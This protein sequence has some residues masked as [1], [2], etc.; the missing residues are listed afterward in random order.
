[1]RDKEYLWVVE[2]C[3]CDCDDWCPTVEV[4]SSRRFAREIKNELQKFNKSDKFRVVR[5]ER[6]YAPRR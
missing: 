6:S 3:E 4:S 1:M 2:A 5:Y